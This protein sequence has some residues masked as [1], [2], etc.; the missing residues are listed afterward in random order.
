VRQ[1]AALFF[2]KDMVGYT[3]VKSTQGVA[4]LVIYLNILLYHLYLQ[5]FSKYTNNSHATAVLVDV[6]LFLINN[7]NR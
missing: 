2:L 6:Y 5:K 4:P 1:A 3:L 7:R